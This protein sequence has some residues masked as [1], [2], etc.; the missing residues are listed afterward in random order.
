MR[1]I[2]ADAGN[3]CRKLHACFSHS[4]HPRGCGEHVIVDRMPRLVEGSSP[5]MRGTPH[6]GDCHHSA[7]RIIPADAGNTVYFVFVIL[8]CQD[9][10]RGCGEHHLRF[11]ARGRPH[12]SSPRMRGTRRRGPADRRDRRIIPADAGN[13]LVWPPSVIQHGDH[14]RGCG[15]HPQVKSMVRHEKGSSPRMRGTPTLN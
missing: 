13:T 12:G 3:T 14:P 1:I 7:G 10:P 8:S 4:D 6:A 11:G 9:H 15:E 5:R 2:P